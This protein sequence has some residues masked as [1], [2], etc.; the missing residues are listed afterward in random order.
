MSDELARID[1]EHNFKDLAGQI[2]A[3]HRACE[4]NLMEG[5][6]H[7][8]EAGRLLIAAKDKLKH[9][10]WLKWLSE[11][12]DISPRMA[13]NYMR[14]SRT[15]PS[16]TEEKAKRLSHLTL[17]HALKQIR[18]ITGK[19]HKPG[20]LE[21]THPGNSYEE[22]ASRSEFIA[23]REA[24]DALDHEIKERETQLKPLIRQRQDKEARL[25]G[26]ILMQ[27]PGLFIEECPPDED[28]KFLTED[29]RDAYVLP[30][31]QMGLWHKIGDETGREYG[32]VSVK[33]DLR[34]MGEALNPQSWA[35]GGS[36]PSNHPR[37]W[38]VEF[39]GPDGRYFRRAFWLLADE[40]EDSP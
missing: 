6:R 23:Q 39:P 19:Q 10:G 21:V 9:G 29:E 25:R 24:I 35:L 36:A 2:N 16:L 12:C 20:V 22:V 40:A 32:A 37:R 14:L 27:L 18:T 5:L 33:A 13:Q 31:M 15:W 3:A 7:A 30:V 28:G 17:Q 4:T 1:S 26:D 8:L 11:Y 38:A 34:R